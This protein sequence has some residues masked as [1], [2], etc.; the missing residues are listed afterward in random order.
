MFY[1]YIHRKKSDNSIFYVGKGVKD[2]AYRKKGRS[3]Y[4]HNVVNKYDYTV[5][6]VQNHISEWIA[7]ELEKYL[8][9]EYR[10]LGYRLCNLTNGGEGISGYS[11]TEESKKKMAKAATG[12]IHTEEARKK[13]SESRKGR[14]LS[15]EV[16]KGISDRM[17]GENHYF[18]GKTHSEDYKKAMSDRLKGRKFTQ[19]H[20]DK[21]GASRKGEKHPLAIKANVYTKEGELIA[22]KVI[23]REWCVLHPEYTRTTLVK[24]AHADRSIPSS[25]SNQHYHKGVYAVY[26]KD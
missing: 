17:K 7:L 14:K 26:I 11:H 22:E 4:W 5:E 21:I 16:I 18:Y 13:M 24:T 15:P 10:T 19:E 6:I 12:K 20:K 8:I 23:L 2:R 3:R 9:S 1:V 25:R